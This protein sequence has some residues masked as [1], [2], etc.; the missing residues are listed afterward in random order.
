MTQSRRIASSFS[1]AGLALL[2]TATTACVDEGM[3][4]PVD[5]PHA[6]HEATLLQSS[7]ADAKP[8]PADYDGDGFT[9]MALKGSNGVWYIDLAK[10]GFGGRWDLAYPGYGG[11]GAV[12]VPA[13]YD[14]DGTV[15]LAVKDAS[16]MWAIDYASNY[17]GVWDVELHGYGDANVVPV[18][19]DY[20][21]DG[22]ADIATKTSSGEWYVDYSSNGIGTTWD[23]HVTGY[24]DATAI[25]V[26]AD[27]D[28]DGKADLAVKDASGTWYIDYA[29]N[30]FDGWNEIHGGYG[31]PTS[32]PVP[33]DYDGDG[34]ADFATKDASGIWSVYYARNGFLDDHTS[35]DGRGGSSST[36]TPGD[37][38]HDGRLDLSV[39]STSGYWF[40]DYAANGYGVW[41]QQVDNPSRVLVDTNA[42]W[43]DAT[44]IYGPSGRIGPVNGQVPL[45]VGVRYTVAVH[46]QAGNGLY[47]AGVE[48]NPDLHV[49]AALNLSNRV[50][51]TGHVRITDTH[52]R[53]FALTCSQPG[54]FP[55]GFMMRDTGPPVG[56][57]S[58]FNRDYGIR[59]ECTA[60]HAGLYGVVTARRLGSDGRYVSGAPIAGATVSTGA[61]TATTAANGSWSLPT[62]AGGP[63]RVTVSRAGF[64]STIAVNVRVPAG[65]GVQIDTPLEESFS[66]LA[67][68][69]MSYTTYI[70]YS[71]GRTILHTVRVDPASASVKLEKSPLVNGHTTELK[72]IAVDKGQAALAMINGG[73]FDTSG[74]DAAVGYFYS[75]GYVSSELLNE[76]GFAW[77]AEPAPTVLQP[78]STLPMLRISGTATQQQ[79]SIVPQ[80]EANFFSTT[81][82]QW[83]QAG[84]PIWDVA[85]RDGVSDVDY[86]LQCSPLLL[87]G[88]LA[89]WR[90][91]HDSGSGYTLAW[92][93]TAVGVT[94]GGVL[95]L[96]VADGEGVNG[97]Q[98]ATYNQLGEFFRD[99]L[100]AT[101]AMNFDGGLSTEMVL[102]GATGPRHVNTITGE[103]SSWDIDPSVTVIHEGTGPGSVFNYLMAGG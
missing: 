19:A 8:V 97:G 61:L 73:F 23:V 98:G 33:A 94:T 56:T 57:G 66:A 32:V 26:P 91:N 95:Y 30:G 41:N 55:L 83:R 69:G 4:A 25:P 63:L 67:A 58:A 74:I 2:A 46:I 27:Y 37:Y 75:R 93:R 76:G 49:P 14:G 21:G 54:S 38:D 35:Y 86:A 68:R 88:G 44:E 28:G 51:T 59:V 36:A 101:T 12:P 64:S 1:L 71:R 65:S 80:S 72:N 70:D 53:R 48:V 29:R 79:I 22:K 34:K 81:S 18:P 15:D 100:G 13:D 43:I 24:G 45:R 20:D 52:T 92:A 6:A 16:G 7:P 82:A 78:A 50:G 11:S 42:P 40:I 31:G 9:D 5:E 62:A 102:R 87:K 3:P 99:V 103:D 10:N 47:S 90:G 85:P 60:A 39:K 84:V 77:Q 89:S 96:V 17:F